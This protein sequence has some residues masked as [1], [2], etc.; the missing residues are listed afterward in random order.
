[1][2][3]NRE[4]A[5]TPAPLLDPDVDAAGEPLL[6][7]LT[8][9][10]IFPDGVGVAPDAVGAAMEARAVNNWALWN[11]WQLELEGIRGV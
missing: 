7:R 4:I 5:T 11:V 3:E 6:E 2:V 1:M 9:V 10:V 8:L